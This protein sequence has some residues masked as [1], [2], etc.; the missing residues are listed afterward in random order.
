M[1]FSRLDGT[2]S[3]A[4]HSWLMLI[5][6]SGVSLIMSQRSTSIICPN[7]A[8]IT[9]RNESRFIE[10]GRSDAR[11]SMMVS[12]ASCS[13]SLRSS[14]RLC[15]ASAAGCMEQSLVDGGDESPDLKQRLIGIIANGRATCK[16]VHR[17]KWLRGGELQ[18]GGI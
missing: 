16:N 7:S 11:R 12:R 5:S 15:C 6:P 1:R 2:L 13:L 4:R 10:V 3:D 14:E 9:C 17:D 8:T 18:S